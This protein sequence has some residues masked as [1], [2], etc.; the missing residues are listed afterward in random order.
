MSPSIL[1]IDPK[2]YFENFLFHNN[3][4]LIFSKHSINIITKNPYKVGNI[5]L[6][7][8]MIQ[9]SISLS[10]FICL[11]NCLCHI[12]F[13]WRNRIYYRIIFSQ[14]TSYRS[15]KCTSGTM[16]RSCFYSLFGKK[17]KIVSIIKNI[18]RDLRIKKMSTFYNYWFW[19]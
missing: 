7:E 16:S 8:E 10:N 3:I 18:F 19:T 2:I 11:I 15:R 5:Q 9:G 1:F 6:W 14:H 4:N 13:S 17:F 12:F